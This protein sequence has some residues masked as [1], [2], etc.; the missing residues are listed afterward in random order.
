MT[1]SDLALRFAMGVGKA[2]P[3]SIGTRLADTVA[4]V[5]AA[6]RS[7]AIARALRVNQWVVSGGAI[8]G[9]ALDDRVRENLRTIAHG[10]YDL[11]HLADDPEALL[12]VV[13]ISSE[14]AEWLERSASEPVVFGAPHLSNFDLAG[15]ALALS[16]LC[17]QVLSV[18]T[19]TDAYRAQNDLRRAAGLDIT[20]I[21]VASLR[22]AAER[23]K[24]GRSVLTGVDRPLAFAK[25]PLRFFGRLA[26]LPDVHI[27]LAERSGAPLVLIW[28]QSRSG[29]YL[30]DAQP[31]P[32][33]SGSSAQS[34]I[35]NAERVLA[36]TEEVI[37]SRPAEWAMPHIVWPDA[38]SE[39]ETRMTEGG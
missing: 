16:G 20:P 19:P 10:L 15:R 13:A 4:D 38:A 23:L 24:D 8:D 26:L 7:S 21:S 31:V 2:M 14:A 34:T 9:E 39:I 6:K 35:A 22:A 1:N 17:A 12:D 37:R 29:G 5:I 33:E 36:A 25:H 11:Y 30:V 27:R 18:P 3:P 28:V 32:V